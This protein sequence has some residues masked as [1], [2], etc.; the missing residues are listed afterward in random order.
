M[1]KSRARRTQSKRSTRSKRS[2][3][4][5]LPTRS[6]RRRTRSK[7]RRSKAY[8]G[9]S[10]K[11]SLQVMVRRVSKAP[12]RQKPPNSERNKYKNDTI[13]YIN[14]INEI[15]NNKWAPKIGHP[16][17]WRSDHKYNLLKDTYEKLKKVPGDQQK[18]IMKMM[19]KGKNPVMTFYDRRY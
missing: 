17:Q 8:R 3:V 9:E 5:K 18:D 13:F 1:G 12:F 16:N 10:I 19:F 11:G 2:K 7:R 6:N 14:K 4:T 15:T